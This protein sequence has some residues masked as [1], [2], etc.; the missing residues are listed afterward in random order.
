MDVKEFLSPDNALADVHASDKIDIVRALASRAAKAINVPAEEILKL[1][2]KR[3]ELGSTGTGGGI[4]VPH[5]RIAGLRQPFGILVRLSNGIDF[6]AIDGQPVDLIFLLLLPAAADKD[7]LSALAA[8]ARTLRDPNS[9][10]DLR[11]ART[12]EDL[13]RA[14]TVGAAH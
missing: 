1:L 12:G 11:G 9:T 4:A 7:Q 13:Y 10:R 8:V 5:A 2:L 14:M 3:E 6:D